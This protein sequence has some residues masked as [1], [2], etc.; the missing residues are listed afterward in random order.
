MEIQHKCRNGQTVLKVS[1]DNQKA[2][3]RELAD[4]VEVFDAEDEC[5]CCKSKS[6]RPRVREVDGNEFYELVCR[7]CGA[8]F[9]FGQHR[10]N[11]TLFP[12]R[13][14]GD[15][16]QLPNRGWAKRDAAAATASGNGN[17]GNKN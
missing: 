17:R 13:Q 4:A 16:S 7:S 12:K 15:S 3:F 10:K 5:G 1:G 2:L 8:R 9:E 14:A 11:N 6:I